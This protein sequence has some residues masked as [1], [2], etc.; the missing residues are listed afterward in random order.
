[1]VG[2]VRS[3][4]GSAAALVM[5]LAG[6][7]VVSSAEATF[8]GK[9]GPIAFQRIVNPE[10]EESSQIFSVARPGAKARKLTSGGNGFNPDYSPDGR[11]IAFE[12]RFGGV[13]PDSIVVMGAD[14]SSPTPVNAS[15]VADPC[16]GD[17]SP[18]WS[19]DGDRLVFERAFGPIVNDEA[20]GGLDLVTAG[21]D[22][23]AEQ[24]ILDIAG[25][26]REPHDAQWSPDGTQ[27]AVNM[28]NIKARPRNGSA[29]Y[30][31][32]ADGSD[33][34]RITPMRL[35]GGSPDWSPDGKRIVFNSS[36]EG[37]AAVE[38]Y[39]VRPDGSGLKRVR[40]EPR[41]KFSASFEPVWSP[42]GKRIAFVHG[43]RTTVPHI[44]TMRRNGKGLRQVTHG[45]KPDVR[46]DWGSR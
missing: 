17:N 15:C 12:R 35:N 30:V 20:S 28:L 39:T 22:G 4:I 19:P 40:K 13:R 11:R 33:F 3:G 36:Y 10:D 14:G 23:S 8:P 41:P 16:L 27:I 21:A 46:P 44:W 24:L 2:D 7:L 25:N 34:R 37:Q 9:P 38:I 42:D 5:L 43:T 45:P 29:I 31:L 6:L 1:V 18:A 32:N 26:A